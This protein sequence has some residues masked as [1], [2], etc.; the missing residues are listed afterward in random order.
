MSQSEFRFRKFIVRQDAAV[1]KVTT[2]GVLLG[3]WSY[4]G[5]VMRILDVGTGTGLLALML[6]QRTGAQI[7]AVEIDRASA[8]QA[9][10]NVALSPWKDRIHIICGSFQ[11][12]AG[13]CDQ[14]Y[15]LI[16]SNPPYF[17][18]AKHSVTKG[19]ATARHDRCLKYEE[20]ISGSKAL[21]APGGRISLII[22]FNMKKILV[23]IAH[24]SGLYLRRELIVATNPGTTPRRALLEFMPVMGDIINDRLSIHDSKGGYTDGYRRL[25]SAFYLAF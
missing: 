11:N 2:D 8:M 23:N 15:D 13:T 25:T 17:R 16:V 21:L 12:F 22:P 14:R 19:S 9:E 24:D 4:T 5:G 3:A 10:E 20:L 7:D 18:G 6:A 1:M